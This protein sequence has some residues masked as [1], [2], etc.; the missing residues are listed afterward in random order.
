MKKYIRQKDPMG[1]G[2]ACVAYVL[3][4]SYKSALKLFAE[5]DKRLSRGY[6]SKDITDALTRFGIC[7][8]SVY[9]GRDK[10]PSV[11]VDSIVYVPKCKNFPRGHYL[12]K[13]KVGYMDPFINL[14]ESNYDVTK[15]KA[16]LRKVLLDKISIKIVNVY[17]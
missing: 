13:T 7:Y 3:N 6:T 15:S 17:K 2:V 9:V 16:G 4:I 14:Q 8:K 5:K 1:C 11:E 10:N 12:V